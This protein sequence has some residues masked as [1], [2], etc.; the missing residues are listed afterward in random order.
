M[1][2][3]DKIIYLELHKTGCSHT[4]RILTSMYEDKIMDIGKHNA[5]H[6]VSKKDIGNFE[7]KIKIG[8]VRNPWDWYVSLWS[9]GCGKKGALYMDTVKYYNN[10]KSYSGIRNRLREILHLQHPRIDSKIWKELYSDVE[11]Y[12]NFRKWLQLILSEEKIELRQG[13]KITLMSN[14]AGLLTYRYMHLYNQIGNWKH[15]NS[16]EELI[17]YDKKNNFI[18]IFL[19]NESLHDDILKMSQE[20]NFDPSKMKGIL[21]NFSKRTNASSRDSDYRKY[22]DEASI[23]LVYK[24]EKLIID[25][26]N[27]TFE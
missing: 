9:F 20:L 16:Q 12:S 10:P 19:K 15:L 26:H 6:E 25:K 21:D 1:L 8:N 7:N 18:D 11:N 4:K 13:Y 2:I 3:S 24:Y 5:I 14:F 27:Y 17:A 22:Y 23:E